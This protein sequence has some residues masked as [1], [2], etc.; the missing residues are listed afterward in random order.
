MAPGGCSSLAQVEARD[1][2]KPT[3][4]TMQCLQQDTERIKLMKLCHN[5]QIELGCFDLGWSI[6]Q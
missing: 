3:V 2:A 4:A 1:D 5:L 6:Q